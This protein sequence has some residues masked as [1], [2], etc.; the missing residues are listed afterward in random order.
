MAKPAARK[1]AAHKKFENV[2]HH[3]K[4]LK[5]QA[6]Q[7]AKVKTFVVESNFFTF[8]MNFCSQLI[9]FLMLLLNQH[10]LVAGAFPCPKT[11]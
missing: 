3:Q 7:K 9:L 6:K 4:K 5:W 2:R 10:F 11:L 1:F 8:E